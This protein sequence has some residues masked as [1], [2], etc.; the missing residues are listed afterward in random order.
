M[1]VQPLLLVSVLYLSAF[2]VIILCNCV[3]VPPT[4]IFC[5]YGCAGH[6]GLTV[7]ESSL[8]AS[9]ETVRRMGLSLGS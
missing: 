9:L 5:V 2:N 3:V 8:M 1:L 7:A 6:C 4:S